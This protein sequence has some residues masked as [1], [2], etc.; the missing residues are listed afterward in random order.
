MTEKKKVQA[1]LPFSYLKKDIKARASTIHMLL[2]KYIPNPEV[3]LYH[4]SPFQLLIAVLLSAQCTD[5]RVNRVTPF[6]FEKGPTPLHMRKLTIEEI[7]TIIKPCGLFHTKAKNI[8][9]LSRIL[10]EEY[11]GRVPS[12]LEILETLPGVGHKTASVVLVQA[13]EQPAFPVDT[14]IHRSALRW[15][16]S[17]ATT[18]IAVER[19]LK[20]IFPETSW[21]KIH[22]QIILYA[23]AFCPAR[24]HVVSECPVCYHLQQSFKC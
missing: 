4:S 10:D 24:G 8:L 13:F 23:R 20:K 21:G 19:D 18:V 11:A 7:E 1:T 15:G 6:L 12:S 16:L 22:L 17:K 14:H 3:P 5:E 2:E 9:E